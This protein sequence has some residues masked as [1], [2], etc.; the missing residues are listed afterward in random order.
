LYNQEINPDGSYMWAFESSNGIR[1]QE[2]GIGGKI[3]NGESSWTAPDGTP[4]QLSYT[5][6]ENGYQ[7]TGNFVPEIPPLIRKA[8]LYLRNHPPAV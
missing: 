7:P 8:L 5:A 4:V 2:E 1:A 6:D 3:A